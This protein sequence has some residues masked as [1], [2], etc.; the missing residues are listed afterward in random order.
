MERETIAR[1]WWRIVPLMAV[2][3]LFAILDKVNLGF[4][5]LTM[6]QDLGLSNTA[7]G[8]AAGAFAIGYLLFGVPAT[9]LLHRLGARRAISLM[10]LAWG[11]C[12]AATAFVTGPQE[13]LVVRFL[14]GMAEA[15]FVPGAVVYFSYWFPSEYRGRVLGSLFFVQPVGLVVAG[16]VSS[17]LLS[18]DGSLGLAGWQ[19]LFVLEALFTFLLVP[20]VFLRMTARPSEAHWLAAAQKE[21]LE[22]RLALES[23]SEQLRT[24]L[25]GWRTL[26]SGRVWALA[27]VYL[28][29]GTSGI[30]LVFFLPLTIKSIG[31]SVWNTGFL[32]AV[33]P[34]VAALTLPLWGIWTDRARSREAVVAVCCSAIVAGLLGAA[35]SLPSAWALVPISLAMSGFFG[36]LAAFWTLPS[37]FLTGAAAAAGIAFINVTGNIGNFTG[38]ALFGWMVDATRSYAAGLICLAASAAVAALVM[39]GQAMRNGR[40]TDAQ[41]AQ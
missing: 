5:A 17:V 2:A 4:A 20:L 19:W 15:G 37:R 3:M 29:I 25:C 34:A 32:A 14:L 40:R 39:S 9:L 30:G 10:M 11:L 6:N 12:S 13:L 24:G 8:T 31:F 23:R 1:I 28:C 27:L 26:A 7:F 22:A 36:C 33:P 16:P 18:F 38:P 41:S 35:A 21:W